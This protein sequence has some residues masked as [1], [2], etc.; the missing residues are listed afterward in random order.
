MYLLRPYLNEHS[1]FCIWL[2]TQEK[3]HDKKTPSHVASPAHPG[4]GGAW[5]IVFCIIEAFTTF[6]VAQRP[7]DRTA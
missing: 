3:V 6:E 5:R 4:C 2:A 1:T 7:L